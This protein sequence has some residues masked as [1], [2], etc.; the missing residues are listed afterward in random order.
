MRSHAAQFKMPSAKLLQDLIVRSDGTTKSGVVTQLT[1]ARVHIAKR[2][3]YLGLPA[4]YADKAIE[5]AAET[6]E[7]L[8][9]LCESPIEAKLLPWL[10]VE[11]YGP[12][13]QTFPVVGFNY[14]LD[15]VV[16]PGDLVIAPQ[17]AFVRY[18]ADFAILA[19]LPHKQAIFAV[20]CDGE[21]FHQ[22]VTDNPRDACFASWGVRTIRASG[23][24]INARPRNVSAL[25]SDA[26][27]EWAG[28]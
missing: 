18:R 21:E 1:Y 5:K 24:E 3:E 6:A 12:L 8:A 11:D 17:F 10:L 13:F 20:E 15:T 25:V 4:S 26:I 2:A 22:A 16:P 9:P 19:R 28:K 27:Q 14:T 7:R 23:A